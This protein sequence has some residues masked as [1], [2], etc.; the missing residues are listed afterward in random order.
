MDISNDI[1]NVLICPECK[2]NNAKLKELVNK[3]KGLASYFLIYCD[4]G[5]EHPFYTTKW[6]FL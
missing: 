3:K 5:Y 1:F 4:C 6:E 2:Q